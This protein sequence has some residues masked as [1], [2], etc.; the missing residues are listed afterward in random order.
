LR[1]A[2][3]LRRNSLALLSHSLLPLLLI[4]LALILGEDLLQA[5]LLGWQLF[6][7]E[8]QQ[9]LAQVADYALAVTVKPKNINGF[10]ELK[11]GGLITYQLKQQL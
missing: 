10:S 5:L 8:P 1:C 9:V 7:T 4:V 6:Q 11:T 2:F 3:N